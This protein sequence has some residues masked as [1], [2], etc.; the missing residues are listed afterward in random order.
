MDLERIEARAFEGL[1]KLRSLYLTTSAQLRI[2]NPLAFE[3]FEGLNS[4]QYLDL[5]SSPLL[6]RAVSELSAAFDPIRHIVGLIIDL[7]YIGLTAFPRSLLA[8]S[9]IYRWRTKGN[10][11]L[12][13]ESDTAENG[14][15]TCSC[16][17]NFM[18]NVKL[19]GG[20][21]GECLCPA[22]QYLLNGAC[23]LC[24]SGT[25]TESS[26]VLLSC[27]KCGTGYT[28][29]RGSSSASECTDSPE[30]IEQR[31]NAEQQQ[32]L[33]YIIIISSCVLVLVLTAAAIWVYCLQTKLNDALTVKVSEQDEEITFLKVAPFPFGAVTE[34]AVCCRIGGDYFSHQICP[35]ALC[36][37]PLTVH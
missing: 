7:S 21:D 14:N 3:G 13:K 15:L 4:L 32:K 23:V 10:P 9:T 37:F 31:N 17:H 36:H 28:K 24:E 8:N 30:T 11:S 18:A 27:T 6:A 5:S 19:L 1:G 12:C 26:N 2:F 34:L 29:Q 33:T 35:L 16:A 20:A 25:Y 22:G